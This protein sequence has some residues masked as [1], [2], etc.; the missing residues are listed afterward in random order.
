M[1]TD[2]GGSQ[3]NQWRPEAILVNTFSR[4]FNAQ[5]HNQSGEKTVTV[6]V[7]SAPVP[8]IPSSFA[9]SGDGKTNAAAS[10][11]GW[12]QK[13]KLQPVS[14]NAFHP[15]FSAVLVLFAKGS[16]EAHFHVDASLFAPGQT[17]KAMEILCKPKR[18]CGLAGRCLFS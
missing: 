17:F 2:W 11:E 9:P 6:V 13:R 1:P 3:A 5:L 4:H 16:P 14:A 18:P 10:L 7:V 12:M 8:L 15:L